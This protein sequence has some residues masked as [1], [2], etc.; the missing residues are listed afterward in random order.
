MKKKIGTWALASMA[1]AS[2]ANAQGVVNGQRTV[3]GRLSVS[4]PDSTADFTAAGST[5]PVKTGTL[6]SR[7][8]ACTRGELYF[9]TDVTAG[10]NLYFCTATGTPGT[11]TAQSAG[12][13][14][15]ASAGSCS[16]A[17]SL[18]FQ[19]NGTD[20][21]SLLNSTLAAF[22]AAGGGCLA[23]DG[24][25]TLR[26]DGQITC[27]IPACRTACRCPFELP[28]TRHR[29]GAG[30]RADD[31]AEADLRWICASTAQN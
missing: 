6:S 28:A 14:S 2:L 4:G 21:T 12:V 13:S 22:Y 25:K 17:S 16:L 7:P 10:Q 5:A 31:W 11:W 8:T 3:L 15:G 26:I 23:I 24:G 1:L 30:W 9:A 29:H 18:G 19:L 20:E 27:R